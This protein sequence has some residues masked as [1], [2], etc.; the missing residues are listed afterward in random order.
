PASTVASHPN[1]H[2][3]TEKRLHGPGGQFFIL[4]NGELRYWHDAVY[5]YGP[6]GLVATL[7]ANFW[8]DPSR[9]WNA[10]PLPSVTSSGNQLTIDPSASVSGTFLVQSVAADGWATDG[11]AFFVT[12]VGTALAANAGA[13]QSANEGA[14][15]QFNGAGTG[16]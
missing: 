8:N 15:V 1:I 6:S 3:L 5:S 16:G 14:S 2:G 13:N 12:V 9:L 10:P 4:P 11:D 7:N